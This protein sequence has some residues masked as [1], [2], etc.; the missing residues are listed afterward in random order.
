M[1][2]SNFFGLFEFHLTKIAR[3]IEASLLALMLIFFSLSFGK[4][5]LVR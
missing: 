4:V 1:E 5:G 2:S 3:E